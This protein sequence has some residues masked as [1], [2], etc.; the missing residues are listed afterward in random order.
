[1]ARMKLNGTFQLIIALAL[2]CALTSSAFSQSDDKDKRLDVRSSAGDLHV[3]G[4]ADLR[5]IGLPPYPGARVRKDEDH[6]NANLALFTSAFGVK[7][8]VMHFDSDDTPTKV[9]AFYRDKLKRYG[10]VLECHTSHGDHVQ[11]HDGGDGDSHHSKD[12]SCDGDNTGP[13]LELKSGTEDDQHAVAVEPAEKGNGATFAVLYV[14][15][16]GKQGDI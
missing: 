16:R 1:M 2:F 11:V 15:A 14:H 10:K 5:A 13:V 4:D 3:G 6:S 12:L 8:L 7:L 9:A